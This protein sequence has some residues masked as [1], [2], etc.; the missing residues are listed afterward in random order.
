MK[1]YM[2]ILNKIFD[3]SISIAKHKIKDKIRKSSIPL[4]IKI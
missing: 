3:A 4:S 2:I 1:I